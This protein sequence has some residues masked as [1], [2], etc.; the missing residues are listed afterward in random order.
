MAII[1]REKLASYASSK[2]GG[3]LSGKVNEIR[4]YTKMDSTTSIFLSHSHKDK[5]IVEQAKIFF[6]TLGIKIYVDW[7]DETMPESPNATTAQNIKT[8]II[9]GNDKFVLLATNNAVASKWC[10]WE[11]GIADSH[12]LVKRKLALFPIA[13]NNNTW[14]GNEYLKIYPRIEIGY[15][16]KAKEMTTILGKFNG[17]IERIKNNF[18][19]SFLALNFINQKPFTTD[20]VLSDK[21]SENIMTAN[22]INSFD[23][24]G[25]N[26]YEN[27]IRRHLLN[28]LVIAYER[29]SMIMYASHIN[30]QTSTEPATLNNR[31]LGAHNFEQ[32]QNIYSNDDKIFLVQL[33]R[34]RNSIVHYNGVYSATNELNYSFGT[35][36]YKSVGNEGQNIAIEFD[37]ILLIYNR[38]RDI[39]KSG[40]DNYFANYP[41]K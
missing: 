11:V 5:N 3:G 10:N 15:N 16:L 7:A 2:V 17:S 9:S 33:R 1:T 27:S 31:K 13:E 18:Y 26:E 28:D 40:N 41:L 25:V 4:T 24:D 35:N 8:Q 32:L 20:V 19:F 12:K 14:N 39:T 30:G 21:L 37:N 36:T 29:Y 34:L 6:E 38:L 23:L 22:S